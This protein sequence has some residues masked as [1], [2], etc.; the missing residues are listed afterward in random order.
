[1]F[2]YC[3]GPVLLEAVTVEKSPGTGVQRQQDPGYPQ[4]EWHCHQERE[5][6]RERKKRGWY[7]LVYRKVNKAPAQDLLCS[8]RPQA[9]SRC[10]EGAEHLLERVLEAQA[11]K[12]TQR[13][14]AL[15]GIN[16][17]RKEKEREKER[18]TRG[19]QASVSKAHNFIFTESFYTLSCI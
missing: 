4:D 7:S 2:E 16:L 13:A 6:K 8:R 14:S 3:F 5:R 12:W 11:G 17:K 15:Q 9:P 18:M 19:D 10:G 1:M